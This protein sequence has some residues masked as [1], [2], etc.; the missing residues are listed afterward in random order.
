MKT[1]ASGH[2]ETVEVVYDPDLTT[3]EALLEVFWKKH[4]ATSKNKQGNDR[5][6]QYRSGIYYFTE[7][8][9]AAVVAS[10]EVQK[11]KLKKPWFKIHTELKPA[12]VFYPAESYHQ[13]Y[14]SEK[15]GRNG[16]AQSAEKMCSDPIRCYG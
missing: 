13:K 3:F 6:T 5:G 2:A 12:A 9:K 11:N 8:Q 14:L 4:D 1:G 10:I 7:E 16:Q 15:G